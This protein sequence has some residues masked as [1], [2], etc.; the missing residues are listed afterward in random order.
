[1]LK[2]M[3]PEP[4]PYERIG[5]YLP[6]VEYEVEAIEAQRLIDVKGFILVDDEEE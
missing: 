2:V 3:I 4:C 5:A 1:M 6:G